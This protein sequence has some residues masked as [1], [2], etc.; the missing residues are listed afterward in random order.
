MKNGKEVRV[1]MMELEVETREDS[2]M[3]V[4]KG[5]AA[6]FN[7]KS[8]SLGSFVEVIAPG[9]FVDSIKK[10]DIRALFNHDPNFVLGRMAAETLTLKE[11]KTGLFMEVDPPDAQWARDLVASIKRRDITGQS[12][13]FRTIK[14][15]WDRKEG[16][17]PLRTLLEVKLFDVGPVTFPAYPDTTVAARSLEAFLQEQKERDLLPVIET[18]RR[19]GAMLFRS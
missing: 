13:S 14:D 9:A 15:K 16:R 19:R 3:P 7:K 5:Y 6:K 10:D 4:I 2:G 18:H 8:E 17:V 1:L 12:F 11:D